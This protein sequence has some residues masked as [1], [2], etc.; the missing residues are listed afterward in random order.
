MR[1]NIGF[2]RHPKKLHVRTSVYSEYEEARAAVEKEVDWFSRLFGVSCT[3]DGDGW[4][5]C[6]WNRKVRV[7]NAWKILSHMLNLETS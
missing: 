4:N 6:K 5:M 3:S 1:G 2:Y 7:F